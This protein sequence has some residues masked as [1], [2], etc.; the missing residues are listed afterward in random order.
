MSQLIAYKRHAAGPSAPS[1]HIFPYRMAPFPRN[2]CS[3][4][5]GFFDQCLK[6]Q[7]LL[8]PPSLLPYALPAGERNCNVPRFILGICSGGTASAVNLHLYPRPRGLSRMDRRIVPP[9]SM[10]SI[11]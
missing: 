6:R 5:G 8:F 9:W 2:A 10:H 7:L 1:M 4:V 3:D 11:S